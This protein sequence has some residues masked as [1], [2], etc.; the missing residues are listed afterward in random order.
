MTSFWVGSVVV[1]IKIITTV[2]STGWYLIDRG[3]H[4]ELYMIN[5]YILKMI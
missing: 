2:I 5:I 4:S 3:E 1:T